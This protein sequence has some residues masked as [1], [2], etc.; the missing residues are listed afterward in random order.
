MLSLILVQF[1]HLLDSPVRV[2]I[3]L[4]RFGLLDRDGVYP[5]GLGRVLLIE[6]FSG[7]LMCVQG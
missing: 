1:V 4:A 7:P 2:D 6:G 3:V 5:L